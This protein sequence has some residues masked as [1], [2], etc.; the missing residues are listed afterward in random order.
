MP[1]S[2]PELRLRGGRSAIAYAPPAT[3]PTRL[4]RPAHPALRRA[5][6]E[7]HGDDARRLGV[8]AG[9]PGR[10]RATRSGWKPV[11]LVPE[12][13]RAGPGR[14]PARASAP[15][16]NQSIWIEVYTGRD[17]PAGLY[18]GDGHG[19][20]PTAARSRVARRA[21]GLRLRAARREQP[22][23]DGLL[24]A[25]ASPS[26]TRAAT[27]TPPTTASPTANRVELVHAYDEAAVRAQPRALRRER[28]HARA[29]GYEGPGE[30]VG[31][32]H[33]ARRPSTGPGT[34]YD[35]RASAWKRGRRLDGV[36]ARSA[37]RGARPS[38]TCPT[39]PRPPQYPD[40][41]RLAGERALEPRPRP[42][43]CPS[44]SPSS[45]VPGAGRAPSTSGARRRRRSTSPAPTQRAGP[46][47]LVSGSTTAGGPTGPTL[48][49]DAPATEARA[50]AWAVVQA[51]RRRL[52]LLARRA[53]AAQPAEA[54]RAE[55]E[56]VG[57][58]RSPSTTAASRT[59]RGPRL[60]QRR[61]RALVPRRGEGAPGGGPRHRRARVDA[62]SSRTSAAACRTTST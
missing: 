52:L 4:G 11:Q 39:S 5:L 19:R 22:A 33:R 26:C 56:R 59:S 3:D 28:L 34:G 21:A 51:R 54:G 55:A 23:R 6:H 31:N 20:P 1:P 42:R 46:R 40:V 36:P 60:H 32:T 15:A 12:N 24:R 18:D 35:E 37:C 8:G 61:R 44:S 7:R 50:M 41:R 43:A 49:I 58:T 57:R 10:A 48:V 45:W 27:S 25:R 13:A 14:L 16:R 29:R 2:L 38:S 9:Q 47:P 17:R 53:L 62:C 30:G